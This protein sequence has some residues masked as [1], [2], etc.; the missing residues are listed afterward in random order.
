MSGNK[1]KESSLVSRE[2]LGRVSVNVI[3]P[4]VGEFAR[5]FIIDNYYL[6]IYG[7]KLRDIV[8]DVQFTKKSI[9]GE[10][11][12][13]RENLNLLQI[14]DLL[15]YFEQRD[16]DSENTWTAI[17]IARSIRRNIVE[18]PRDSDLIK[19]KEDD[20]IRTGSSRRRRGG[21]V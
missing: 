6:T 11:F 12:F 5:N 19:R 9:T 14:H 20:F 21:L 2:F 7:R 13:Y 16:G 17:N 15:D 3:D 10:T 18:D 4:S 8:Y 1:S